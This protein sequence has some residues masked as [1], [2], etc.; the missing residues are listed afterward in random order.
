MPQRAIGQGKAV[1]LAWPALT[2]L[3][4]YRITEI[5]R[6]DVGETDTAG[7]QPADQG[8][9]Q[10]LAALISAY[11]AGAVGTEPGPL[12]VG[13]VRHRT[14]GPVQLLTAGPGLVG[15]Q[16]GGQ[17][18]LT[19]PAGAARAAGPRRPGRTHDPAAVLAG[20][21]RDQRRTPR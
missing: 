9:T 6:R 20:H 21:R 10:R 19:L 17:V 4:A 2:E 16:D 1:T 13:W 11:H 7:T 5:P 15:S 18:L 8:R 14:G 12:A 3:S